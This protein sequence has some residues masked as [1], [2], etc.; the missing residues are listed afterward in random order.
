M[1]RSVLPLTLLLA[2]FAV[3]VHAQITL[4][5]GLVFAEQG[6]LF[7]A[8]NFA[9]SG[10]AFAKD[11]IGGGAFAPTHTIP[12]LNNGTY[13]NSSSWIGDSAPS[14]AGIGLASLQ[15]IASFAFGRSNV[16]SGD[17]CGGGVCTDRS[18]GDYTI[19]FTTDPDPA[20]NHLTAVWNTIG[21]MTINTGAGISSWLRHRFNLTT[22]VAATGFRIITPGGNAI[23]EIELYSTPGAIIPL[24]GGIATSSSPGYSLTWDGNDGVNFGGGVPNNLALA[25]NGSAAFASGALGP[26][27]G[28]PFHI[29]GNL[30][31]GIYGNG[32]SWIGGDGDPAPFHAGIMFSSLVDVSSISWGR[33]NGGEAQE[34]TDRSLGTFTI[35]RTLDPAGSPGSWETLGTVAINFS[36]DTVPGGGITAHLRHE[37][38]LSDGDGGVLARGIRV[39]VPATG[40]GG[41]TAI[42]EIEVYGTVIPEPSAA[43]LA[44]AGA[45]LLLRRR[46]ES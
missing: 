25:A 17:P 20:L 26:Q 42:D 45:G 38:S 41:G 46:R 30:N 6:G 34:F 23:D 18:A 21:T 31:D 39:L 14:Y 10:T 13:G 37:F 24:P 5:P 36:D 33:D 35:E 40:I 19:E 27:L 4:S 11:L 8:G 29:P 9:T 44:L 1:N 12:N 16:T 3:T 28:L 32:N 22:P 43:V 15:N 7:D 2:P